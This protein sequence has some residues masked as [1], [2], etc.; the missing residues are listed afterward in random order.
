MGI[1]YLRIELYRLLIG[2]HC[3]VVIPLLGIDGAEVI[4]SHRL[5][6]LDTN[7][8]LILLNRQEVL[9][10]AKIGIAQVDQGRHH[11]GFGCE[12]HLVFPDFLIREPHL[13]IT[14]SQAVV[15]LNQVRLDFQRLFEVSDGPF[16][17]PHL[18]VNI[19]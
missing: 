1:A 2:C 10:F 11:I 5:V 12:N 17:I 15:A 9:A 4:M 3:P 19:S 6:R 16:I 7:G 14:G 18:A 13:V 8:L